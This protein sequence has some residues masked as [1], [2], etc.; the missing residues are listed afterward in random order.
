MK[1]RVYGLVLDLPDDCCAMLPPAPDEAADLVVAP[2]STAAQRPRLDGEAPLFVSPTPGPDG[3]SAL[4]VFRRGAGDDTVYDFQ[5][6]RGERLLSAGRCIEFRAEDR[7]RLEIHLL[8]T[9][10]PFWLEQRG[11][12]ALHGAVAEVGGRA[13]ALLGA[14]GAGK[15]SLLMA[16]LESGGRLL[17]DDLLI[18]DPE[19]R[20]AHPAVP[21]MRLWLDDAARWRGA[22]AAGGY[23]RVVAELDKRWVPVAPEH[24][25]SVPRCLALM[26][27]PRRREGL[28]EASWQRISPS[29]AVA[30]LLRHSRVARLAAAAGLEA[31]RLDRLAGLAREVP[32][33]SLTYPSGVAR[34][35]AAAAAVAA[36]LATI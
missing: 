35:P 15:S 16:L 24:F 33:R 3:S 27:L 11:R 4:Q 34:L 30:E 21:E 6:A 19:T 36:E 18:V 26:V 12:L 2:M 1:R 5:F 23:Q 10:L 20:E 22:E 29:A 9:V 31:G 14:G 8:G 32:M 17:S 28:A 13:V 7:R 25:V